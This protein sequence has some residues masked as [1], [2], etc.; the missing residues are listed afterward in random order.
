MMPS[1]QILISVSLS[2][3][4]LTILIQTII[5]STPHLT[6]YDER[7]ECSLNI[8]SDLLLCNGFHIVPLQIAYIVSA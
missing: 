3:L 6:F 2:P 8:I 4:I 7:L 1:P 5:M